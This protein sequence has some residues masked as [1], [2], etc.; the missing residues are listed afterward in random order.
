VSELDDVLAER[1][2]PSPLSILQHLIEDHPDLT[3]VVVVVELPDGQITALSGGCTM[4]ETLGMLSYAA[5]AAVR[6]ETTEEE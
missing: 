3:A 6:L 4:V 1:L 2:G 5:I